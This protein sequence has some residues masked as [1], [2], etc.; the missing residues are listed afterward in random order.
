MT[1]F[2]EIERKTHA[3]DIFLYFTPFIIVRG[4]KKLT[5][6][7]VRSFC[8]QYFHKARARSFWLY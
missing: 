8:S 6:C 5:G 1:F 7:E 3:L 4:L 2:G